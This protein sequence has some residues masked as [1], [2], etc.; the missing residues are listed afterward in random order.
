MKNWAVL[1]NLVKPPLDDMLKELDV[2]LLVERGDDVDDE[3][4]DEEEVPN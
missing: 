4:D 1:R 2:E 3:D